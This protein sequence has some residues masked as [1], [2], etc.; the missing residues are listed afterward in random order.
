MRALL[1]LGALLL[2]PLLGLL[3]AAAQTV[4]RVGDQRGGSRA[5]ME[6][7]GVLQDLPYRL[8][9]HEFPAAAPLLEALNAGA[10]DTGIAGDA[11]FTFAAAAGAPIAAIF[12]IRQDQGG[13]AVLVRKDAPFRSFA[14]LKGRRIGTGRGSIGH[15]LVLA[16]LEAAGLPPDAVS[17]S[18]LLPADAKAALLGGSIDAW[19]TWEPYTTQLE[20][21]GDARALSDGRGLT[22]GLSFQVARR[23]AIAEKRP[24]LEDFVQRLAAAR[25]WARSHPEAFAAAWSRLIGLPP[26][27]PLAWFRRAD[28]RPVALDAA[29][30]ADEQRTIDLYRRHRLIPAPLSAEALVDPSFNAAAQRGIAAATQ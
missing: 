15:Q 2:A 29:V 3:P 25:V 19:A 5:V 22:P 12:A 10:I 26:E 24:A 8:D 18:F 23:D 17:V 1:A 11:P 6:A 14:D 9:W 13:L 4:L 16:S 30:V 28:I 27:V 7:A 21:S 20:L